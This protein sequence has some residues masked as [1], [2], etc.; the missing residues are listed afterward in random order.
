MSLLP[1]LFPGEPKVIAIR[2]KRKRRR[3]H[4]KPTPTPSLH[5]Q[6]KR[7][8]SLASHLPR[9]RAHRPG[10][11]A[12]CPG[13]VSDAAWTRG[14]GW[15]LRGLCLRVGVCLGECVSVAR[16]GDREK[17]GW[18]ATTN[19]VTCLGKEKS[20]QNSPRL[21]KERNREAVT[22]KTETKNRKALK[23]KGKKKYKGEEGSGS[24]PHLRALSPHS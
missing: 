20:E 11:P 18:E 7:N 10:G 19:S 6:T 3:P 9:G 21:K 16:A 5:P 22:I 1:W 2:I 12:C 4:F 17:D 8:T 14:G 23:S 15:N 13:G 24:R